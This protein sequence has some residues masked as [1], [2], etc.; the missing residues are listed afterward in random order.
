MLWFNFIL[1]S[2][3]FSFVSNSLSCY[4]HTLPY[5]PQERVYF[6]RLWQM[7]RRIQEWKFL[8]QNRVYYLKSSQ[9]LLLKNGREGLKLVSK[10]NRTQISIWKIPPE[11]RP[12]FSDIRC[13]RTFS[14]ETKTING[15]NHCF[16][17]GVI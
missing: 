11:N 17:M 2:N 5:P 7:V 8:L 12:T 16:G 13:S 4:Y 1:G 3:F 9:F 14:I 6:P 15:K 10:I